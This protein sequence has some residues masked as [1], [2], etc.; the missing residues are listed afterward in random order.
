M[1]PLCLRQVEVYWLFQNSVLFYCARN[2][3]HDIYSLN[4]FLSVLYSIVIYRHYVVKQISRTSSFCIS[5]T[6]YLFLA[7]S[8]FILS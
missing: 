4:R 8:H 7:T 2:T 1:Y 3:Y 6:L 5:E